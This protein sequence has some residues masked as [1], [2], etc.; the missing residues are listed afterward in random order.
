MSVH[1]DL[2]DQ[3]P[4][5]YYDGE[6]GLCSYAVKL[7]AEEDRADRIS[8]KALQSPEG[9]EVLKTFNIHIPKTGYDT[10]VFVN[11]GKA[12]TKSTAALEIAKTLGGVWRIALLSYLIPRNLRDNIYDW[13]SKNR[14]TFFGAKRACE[15][16]SPAL[17]KKL[18]L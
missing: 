2:A 5:V 16:P 4:T 1:L 11:E 14:L 18:G 13:I 15:I 8:I 6:C 3:K 7:I 10:M 9:Q 17:R 12:Y